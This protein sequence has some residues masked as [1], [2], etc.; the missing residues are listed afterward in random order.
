MFA[1]AVLLSAAWLAAIASPA[2]AQDLDT[3][4]KQWREIEAE[5]P[6]YPKAENLVPFSGG[7]ASTHQFFV[8]AQSLS[9]GADGVVRYTL[10]IKTSGGAMNVT[11]EGIRC[12]E[13]RQKTYA[14]GQP[15]G[16]W[17]RAR[18]PDWR[19]IEYR[20]FNNHH[21]ILHN[22][23]LCV[24]GREPVQTPKEIVRLLRQPSS[25]PAIDD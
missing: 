5:L 17:T 22:E 13:R 25:R 18:D 24:A 4:R 20:T 1:R 11:H 2:P 8:D 3:E 7:P 6:A 23:Y 21:R 15:Q 16:G 12:D 14:I 10:V 19:Y 9:I